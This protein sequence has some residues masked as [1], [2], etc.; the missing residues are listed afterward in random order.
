V[1]DLLKAM[2]PQFV[3]HMHVSTKDSFK[4]NG[5]SDEIIDEIVT[6]TLTA[7][8]GQ[9]TSVHGFVGKSNLVK[10]SRLKSVFLFLIYS[11]LSGYSR[12]CQ[13]AT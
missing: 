7:N 5:F 4:E 10:S 13:A 11:M 9:S 2:S 3:D 6:A 12:N 8:Y 1:V